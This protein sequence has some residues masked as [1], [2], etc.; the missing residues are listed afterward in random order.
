MALGI[1]LRRFEKIFMLPNYDKTLK[2]G[3]WVIV[4][5]DR[6]VEC[7]KVVIEHQRPDIKKHQTVTVHKVLGAATAEDLQKYLGLE[8]REKEAYIHGVQKVKEHALP[9]RL[10][11]VECLFDGTK[12]IFYYKKEEGK[13][14][15][16]GK[17]KKVQ[18]HFNIRELVNDLSQGLDTKVD[19]RETGLRGEAKILGGMGDCGLA[20]CCARWLDKSKPVTVKMAKEQGIPI[21]LTKI[22]GVCGRLKC[23][24]EYEH[25]MYQ[26]GILKTKGEGAAEEDADI[27]KVFE[28]EDK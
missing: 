28:K 1:K 25:K 11:S 14:K 10:I 12:T 13:G 9:I 19:M 8:D 18:K 21:N 6:G 17:H 3:Q 22:S 20:L 26:Q 24:M 23:C 16:K 5:T 27:K 7:G 15:D 2:H 4:E